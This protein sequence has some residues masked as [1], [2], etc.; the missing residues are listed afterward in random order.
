M[1][2]LYQLRPA[3]DSSPAFFATG[4]RPFFLG[5]GLFATA[6]LP[7]WLWAYTRGA[8]VSSYYGGY[9]WHGHEMLF[10]YCVAVVAGFLLTAVKNW[11]GLPTAHGRGLAALFSV[12]LLGR[13]LPLYPG[14]PPIVCAAVDLAFL[15]ALAL[16]LARPIF[17]ARKARNFFVAPLLLLMTAANALVH[18]DR[19]GF[20]AERAL[21]GLWLMFDLVALLIAVIGGR[22]IAF[23]TERAVVGADIKR[24]PLFE[25]PSVIAVALVMLARPLDIGSVPMALLLSV[26]ALLNGLRLFT[27]HTPGLWRVPLLWVLHTGYFWLVVSLGMQAYGQWTAAVWPTLTLHAGTV[28]AIGVLTL[29]MM[30]RVALGHTGRALKAPRLVVFAF[31][32]VN[33][34]ALVRVVLPMTAPQYYTALVIAAG[35]LWTAAFMFF[36]WRYTSILTAPRVDGAPG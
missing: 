22:V 31:G 36:T 32:L 11:T 13:L 7:L 26:A 23:F 35:S 6:F 12:W 28:G 24:R 29:G 14:T 15:P 25:M 19:L 27:W 4:F 10:G 20:A 34:A 2:P 9:L 17:R 33:L 21:D 3:A 16:V 1:T 30:A 18:A 5:A 8:E